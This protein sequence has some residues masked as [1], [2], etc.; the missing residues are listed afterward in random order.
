MGKGNS[1]NDD[2]LESWVSTFDG[3]AVDEDWF[4]V[5]LPR[6]IVARRFTFSAGRVSEDGGWFDARQGKP[7][8][9]VQRTTGADW[10]TIGTLDG[11]PDTTATEA[12]DVG[13][14]WDLAAYTL[15]VQQ[16]VEFVAVRVIG[17]P[18]GGK[19]PTRPYVT[20]A[21]LQAFSS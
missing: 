16:P 13:N 1:F 11:Y 3:T 20:C 14:D 10:Q 17:R 8:V 12:R 21:A 7:R 2:D 19:D 9:Q 15:N 5:A 18:A 4:A 6:L